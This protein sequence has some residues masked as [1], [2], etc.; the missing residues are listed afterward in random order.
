MGYYQGDMKRVKYLE[1]Y[2]KHI[3]HVLQFLSLL[4]TQSDDVVWDLKGLKNKN[5]INKIRSGEYNYVV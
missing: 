4:Y 2:L 1:R 3:Q 5:N